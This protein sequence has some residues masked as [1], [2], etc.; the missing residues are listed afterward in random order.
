MKKLIC[1][2]LKHKMSYSNPY[3]FY[4]EDGFMKVGININQKCI[5]CHAK[6]VRPLELFELAVII[7]SKAKIL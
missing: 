7:T 1:Y 2:F 3:S 6:I 4:M 5:R